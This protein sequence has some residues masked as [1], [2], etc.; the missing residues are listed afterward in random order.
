[1]LLL[2]VVP[3]TENRRCDVDAQLHRSRQSL[4][5]DIRSIHHAEELLTARLI[6][7]L[8]SGEIKKETK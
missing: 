3:C 4:Q 7:P 8:K 1:M 5:L 2:E 6:T